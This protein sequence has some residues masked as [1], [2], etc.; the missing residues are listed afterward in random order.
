MKAGVEAALNKLLD[1]IR[2]EFENDKEFQK[3]EALAYPPVVVEKKKK[4]EKKIGAGYVPK[5]KKAAGEKAAAVA[6]GAIKAE[7]APKESVGSGTEDALKK[8]SVDA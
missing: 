5:D 2:E 4:K 1:P 7:D 3:I 8:L 6:E